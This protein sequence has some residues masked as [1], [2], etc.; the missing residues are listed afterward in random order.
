MCDLKLTSEGGDGREGETVF[1]LEGLFCFHLDSSSS[2]ASPAGSVDAKTIKLRI[3]YIASDNFCL[4]SN[5]QQGI[6]RLRCKKKPILT[7]QEA[8]FKLAEKLN[9]SFNATFRA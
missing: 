2:R 7:N 1:D 4:F 9:Y 3:K 5:S 8:S 6:T